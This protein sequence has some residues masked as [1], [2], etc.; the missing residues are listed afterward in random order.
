MVSSEP[1]SRRVKPGVH[2][3]WRGK[4]HPV[5]FICHRV[6]EV[7]LIYRTPE[8][9]SPTAHVRQ[10]C[11]GVPTLHGQPVQSTGPKQ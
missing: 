7:E 4:R 10:G 11:A 8:V 6:R 2:I 5:V 1:V 3:A 9:A